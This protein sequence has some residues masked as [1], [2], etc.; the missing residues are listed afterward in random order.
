[1]LNRCPFVDDKLKQLLKEVMNIHQCVL[2]TTI[3]AILT[4]YVLGTQAMNFNIG[5]M[6]IPINYQTTRSQLFTPILPS[7]TNRLPIS[8]Y[9]MWYNVIP[10]FVPL[11]HSLYLAYPIG[12]KGLDSLIFKNY[13]SY[14]P[15]NVY[16]VLEQP[17]T[18]TPYSV[19]N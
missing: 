1:M 11:D 7:K 10:P 9:P 16:P 5:H 3:I 13:T 19:E 8:T 12:T 2:P 4:V 17:P 6:A 14:V 18:Y 15:R